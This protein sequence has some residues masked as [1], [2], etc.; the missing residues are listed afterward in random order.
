MNIDELINA[1]VKETRIINYGKID[2]DPSQLIDKN[3][4]GEINYEERYIRYNDR[5]INR[6]NRKS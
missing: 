1:A 2:F 6:E 4:K 5:K 3:I